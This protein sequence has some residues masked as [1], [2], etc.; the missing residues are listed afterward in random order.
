MLAIVGGC[1]W[2]TYRPMLAIYMYV[3]YTLKDKGGSRGVFCVNW[4]GGE[5][6]HEFLCHQ[7]EPEI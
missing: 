2:Y 6:V 5:E 3:G 7:I 4:E 1:R